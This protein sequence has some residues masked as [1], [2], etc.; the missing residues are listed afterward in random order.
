LEE[1][2]MDALPSR[3]LHAPQAGFSMVE[4]LMAAL[5]LAIGI[6]GVTMMQLMAIRATRGSKNL[7]RRAPGAPSTNAKPRSRWFTKR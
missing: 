6:L 4:M 1:D 2:L 5:I 7:H 3:R